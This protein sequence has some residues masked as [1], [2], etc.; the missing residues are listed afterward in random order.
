MGGKSCFCFPLSTYSSL[1]IPF[2]LPSPRGNQCPEGFCDT[3]T[4]VCTK[5]Q[6]PSQ[7]HTVPCPHHW[8]LATWWSVLNSEGLLLNCSV[9]CRLASAWAN[10]QTSSVHRAQHT[11]LNEA[12]AV[13]SLPS[14]SN[15]CSPSA[16]EHHG[17]SLYPVTVFYHWHLIIL[18]IKLAFYCFTG[19][20]LV[21][22]FWVE[23]VKENNS[24]WLQLL[25]GQ[26]HKDFCSW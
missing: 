3:V 21:Q 19:L 5:Q 1:A 20:R 13:T 26:G 8:L 16:L 14:L 15:A 11:F 10:L 23:F 22:R 18:Y 2:L 9:T 6:L 25:A 4:P 12:W 24:C 7:P 17:V